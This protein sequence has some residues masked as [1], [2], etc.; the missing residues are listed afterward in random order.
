MS[1]V[2]GPQGGGYITCYMAMNGQIQSLREH[3]QCSLTTCQSDYCFIPAEGPHFALGHEHLEK[4]AAAIVHHLSI[5]DF[6]VFM[7]I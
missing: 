6:S 3:W 4:W 5:C 1:M 2:A 7:E